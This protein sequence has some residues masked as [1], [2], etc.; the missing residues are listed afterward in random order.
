[1]L[2][3]QIDSI[4]TINCSYSHLEKLVEERRRMIKTLKE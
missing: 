3:T 1:M 4:G 2:E